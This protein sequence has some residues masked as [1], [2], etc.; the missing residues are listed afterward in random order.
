ML[1]ELRGDP[2]LKPPNTQ[3]YRLRNNPTGALQR[4]KQRGGLL[5]FAESRTGPLSCIRHAAK[6]SIT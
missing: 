3:F 1:P 2:I 5:T 6:Q 4:T